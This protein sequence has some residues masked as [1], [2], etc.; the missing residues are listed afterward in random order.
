M[1]ANVS[2]ERTEFEVI[3]ALH[4]MQV[5]EIYSLKEAEVAA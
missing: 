3:E 2:S 4:E 5:T 1:W